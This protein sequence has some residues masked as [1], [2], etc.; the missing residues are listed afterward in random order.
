MPV[1][2]ALG[3]LRQDAPQ[4]LLARW[5]PGSVRDLFQKVKCKEIEDNTRINLWDIHTQHAH[6]YTH[7]HMYMHA[8]AHIHTDKCMHR[9][10]CTHSCTHAHTSIH[11]HVYTQAHT[12]LH[13]CTHMHTHKHTTS[14][15]FQ[16]KEIQIRQQRI[17]FSMSET[18]KYWQQTVFVG[19]WR[20][21][22]HHFRGAQSLADCLKKKQ[23]RSGGT[24]HYSV[25]LL[26]HR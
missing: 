16:Q 10:A 24:T 14:Q 9:H 5:S 12:C 26:C 19:S 22:C 21:A 6:M 23:G 4:S 17:W 15:L 8:H 3:I 2:T 25:F 11:A 13:T 7:V 20:P 18:W 1:T